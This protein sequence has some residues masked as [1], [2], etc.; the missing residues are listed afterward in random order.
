MPSICAQFYGDS[1]NL[2]RHVPACMEYTVHSVAKGQ[3]SNPNILTPTF[4]SNLLAKRREK[5]RGSFGLKHSF[6]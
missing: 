6:A 2:G 3:N 4:K 1:D 5:F